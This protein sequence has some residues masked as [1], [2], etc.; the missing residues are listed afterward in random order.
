MEK[1]KM[2]SKIFKYEVKDTNNKKS[3]II[4]CILGLHTQLMFAVEQQLERLR[5]LDLSQFADEPE[6]YESE[7][8][9]GNVLDDLGF[10]R[11]DGYIPEY[12]CE[13]ATVTKQEPNHTT[14]ITSIRVAISELENL[15]T[16]ESN[17]TFK[18][19]SRFSGSELETLRNQL[20]NLINQFNNYYPHVGVLH[21]QAR[22]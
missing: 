1:N 22:R 5:S 11:F 14:S 12:I 18:D 2:S 19:L 4:L 6:S 17:P 13:Y 21:S 15:I 20:L 10:D 7:Y 8:L 3:E 16:V 9:D